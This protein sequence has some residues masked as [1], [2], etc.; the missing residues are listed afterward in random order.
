[1]EN[2]SELNRERERVECWQTEVYWALD[3]KII[4]SKGQWCQ[5]GLIQQAM[6]DTS[7]SAPWNNV[8]VAN[9]G[10]L[11]EV[12]T[13]TSSNLSAREAQPEGSSR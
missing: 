10:H 9:P 5:T 4:Y 2:I 7:H 13:L 12:I 6:L 3:S 8:S 11:C 1:M